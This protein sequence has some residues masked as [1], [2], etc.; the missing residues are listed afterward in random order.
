MVLSTMIYLLLWGLVLNGIFIE[1]RGQPLTGKPH[2]RNL[3]LHFVKI[4]HI[5]IYNK[6]ETFLATAH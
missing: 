4:S 2:I 3:V 1:G 6:E 5:S